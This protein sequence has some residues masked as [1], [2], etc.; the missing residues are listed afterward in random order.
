MAGAAISARNLGKQYTVGVA[1]G[2]KSLREALM[3]SLSVPFRFL[4][5]AGNGG[6]SS[7]SHE[8][9]WALKDVSLDIM[10]GEVVGIVGRNGAG[11]STL[12][13][14]L[15]RITEPTTG[16]ADIN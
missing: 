10:P 4:R 8:T 14:I 13:K 6:S 15:A 9:I 5:A 1:R 16:T 11:K 12:L 2:A 7:E 3:E